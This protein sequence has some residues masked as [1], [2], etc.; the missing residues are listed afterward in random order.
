M[1]R[2]TKVLSKLDLLFSSIIFLKDHF[3]I[4][5]ALGLIAAFGRVI[6]LGGLG[7]ISTLTNV[8]LEVV[9]ETSRVIIFL[10]VLGVAN[11]K[12]GFYQVRQLFS[13]KSKLRGIRAIAFQKLKSNWVNI[14]L[15]FLG[16]LIIAGTINF[17]IDQLAYQ[18]CLYLSLKR[19]GILVDTSSEWTILLFFK[20]ILVIPFTLVFET[21]FLLWITDKITVKYI[22]L[23]EIQ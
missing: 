11:I 4:L 9:V 14:S 16:F 22:H 15:S 18:T 10:Y 21:I 3:V 13:G 1:N 2:I 17:L 7:E 12:K 8:I 6:Q 19:E 5:L 20:N 23:H